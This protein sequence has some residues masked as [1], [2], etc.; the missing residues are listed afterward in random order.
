MYILNVLAC[1]SVPE[2]SVLDQFRLCLHVGISAG[3][4]NRQGKADNWS[5][6]GGCCGGYGKWDGVRLGRASV[7]AWQLMCRLFHRS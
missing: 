6:N 3:N 2:P 4:F 7:I 1:F 5:T